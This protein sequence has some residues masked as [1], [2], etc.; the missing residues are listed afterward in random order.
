MSTSP[1]YTA[2][3]I[4]R[5]MVLIAAKPSFYS[6]DQLDRYLEC[7]GLPSISRRPTLDI[8]ELVIRH[9]LM[10]FP[11]ENTEMHYTE[12]GIM[13]VGPER[14]FQRFV[15]DKKGGSYCFGQNTLMLGML[16]ALGFR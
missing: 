1:L 6:S 12:A 13:D 9:H 10:T 7:L 8:L 5:I 14:I 15:A 2:V 3:R 11:W 16:L 4:Y